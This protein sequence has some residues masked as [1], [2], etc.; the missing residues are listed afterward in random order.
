[1]DVSQTKIATEKK[2]LLKI[3]LCAIITCKLNSSFT[4]SLFT[5]VHPDITIT[6]DWALKT[7]HLRIYPHE[8]FLSEE[9][10]QRV[11][12]L[13]FPAFFA[14]SSSRLPA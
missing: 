12:F 4:G 8:D 1:M 11:L 2:N 13:Y 6:V 7:N 3:L 9:N 14:C 10:E 5:S